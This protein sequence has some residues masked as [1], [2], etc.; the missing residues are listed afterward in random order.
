VLLSCCTPSLRA[1]HAQRPLTGNTRL[2]RPAQVVPGL[3]T[4]SW[5]RLKR[6][7]W[8]TSASSL[9]V[10]TRRGRL[11]NVSAS[12]ALHCNTRVS[13]RRFRNRSIPNT[14]LQTMAISPFP[15]D[16]HQ[17][18]CCP[19]PYAV[20]LSRFPSPLPN[21]VEGVRPP[22]PLIQPEAEKA[23]NKTHTINSIEHASVPLHD[24]I[25]SNGE[26]PLPKGCGAA[27]TSQRFN[28]H[29]PSRQ[30]SAVILVPNGLASR[31]RHVPKRARYH[32]HRSP[33]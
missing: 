18:T 24:M 20:I 32:P 12:R 1:P 22:R 8:L 19:V 16:F 9:S 5:H 28:L 3:A 11:A 25:S 31:S 2:Q 30:G 7:A 15:Y 29:H 27:S 21:P 6:R 33:L 13:S 23:P 14:R 26:E 17:N 4:G 10:D